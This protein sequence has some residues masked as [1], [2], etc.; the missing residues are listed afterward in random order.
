MC[1]VSCQDMRSARAFTTCHRVWWQVS[2]RLVALQ[3]ACQQ[4]HTIA[5]GGAV[6]GKLTRALAKLDKT[7]SMAW[8]QTGSGVCAPPASQAGAAG[9][10]DPTS[11]TQPTL[12]RH[13]PP[14]TCTMLVHMGAD[15]VKSSVVAA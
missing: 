12:V 5:A 4:L 13:W 15:A 14:S 10:Q 7:E 2:E 3:E 11:A 6:T 8:M 9:N 1:P